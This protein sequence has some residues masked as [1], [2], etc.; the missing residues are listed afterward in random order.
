MKGSEALGDVGCEGQASAETAC[1][2]VP[3]DA[4]RLVEG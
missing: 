2:S 1:A 4:A 3:V